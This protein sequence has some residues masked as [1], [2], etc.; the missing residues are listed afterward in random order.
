MHTQH[1]PLHTYRHI[2]RLINKHIT[3]VNNNPLWRDYV[4]E[5]FKS[6]KDASPEHAGALLQVAKLYATFLHDIQH[7]K[8]G[9]R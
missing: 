7:H 3:N 4:R 8:V 1:L 6:A 5:Q 2:L 9:K